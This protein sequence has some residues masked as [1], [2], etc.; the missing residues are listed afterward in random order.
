MQKKQSK[1]GTEGRD[2]MSRIVDLDVAIKAIEDMPNCPN[3]F[4]DTYDK[5]CIIGVLEELATAQPDI[6][7]CKDCKHHSFDAGY[8]YDWCNR[9][10]GIFRVKPYDFCSRAERRED[11]KTT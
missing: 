6:I 5:A 11:G 4:S 3:G 2:R 8:G 7:R 1:H 9:T 10:S